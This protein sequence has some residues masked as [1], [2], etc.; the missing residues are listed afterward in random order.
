M[1]NQTRKNP[2]KTNQ[3]MKSPLLLLWRRNPLMKVKRKREVMKESPTLRKTM[4]K[5]RQKALRKRRVSTVVTDTTESM[6][7]MESTDTT[8]STVTTEDITATTDTMDTTDI[9]VIM[10]DTTVIMDTTDI[11][12]IMATTEA[13]T[14]IT[15]TTDTTDIMVTTEAIT[16]IT[17]TT[18]TTDIIIITMVTTH[19]Q[20]HNQPDI[21]A[22]QDHS[23]LVTIIQ[24][25]IIVLLVKDGIQST[26]KLTLEIS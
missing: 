21:T 22:Q 17:D 11:M 13:T 1:K 7:I 18:D 25:V 8:E 20:D 12:V 26:S 23:Q 2:L 19:T 16:D 10:E 6:A 15:V 4:R 3:R 24:L 9:T 5:R 14:V